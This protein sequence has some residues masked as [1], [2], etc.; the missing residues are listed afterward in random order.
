MDRVTDM[1][2]EALD[3]EFEQMTDSALGEFAT[4]NWGGVGRCLRRAIDIA[5]E[6]ARREMRV[7]QERAGA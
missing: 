7:A 5:H 3:A 2:D 6:V 1:A 4:G